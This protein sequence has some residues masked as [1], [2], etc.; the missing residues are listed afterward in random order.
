MSCLKCELS[1]ALCPLPFARNLQ[2]PALF[3]LPSDLSSLP[4]ALCPLLFALHFLLSRLCSALCAAPS[5][6]CSLFS[7]LCSL[8]FP[9]RPLISALNLCCLL[10]CCPLS[11][12]YTL[13]KKFRYDHTAKGAT[14]VPQENVPIRYDIST[15]NRYGTYQYRYATVPHMT[16]M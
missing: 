16:P 11:S 1:P 8:P 4:S 6:C 7:A 3:P 10:L 9:L 12:L 15:T 2:F 5:A 14:S 13:V